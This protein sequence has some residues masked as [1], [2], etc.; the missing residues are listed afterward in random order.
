M[1]SS[2]LAELPK[3]WRVAA[4]HIQETATPVLATF[5]K[6]DE[7][8]HKEYPYRILPSSDEIRNGVF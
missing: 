6:T 7:Q 4:N 8:R 3:R 2:K 1:K 5:L